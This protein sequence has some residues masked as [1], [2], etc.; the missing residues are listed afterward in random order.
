MC[1]E[2]KDELLKLLCERYPYVMRLMKIMGVDEND[3]EDVAGEIFIDAFNGLDKLRDADKM[4]PWLKTIASN[5]AS[6]YFSKR[7][8]R[9]EISNMVKTEAGEMDIFDMAADEI[10]VEAVLQEAEE[11][12]L[13][14]R[15]VNTLPDISRR[16][17]RMRFWGEYKH[18]EIAEILNIKLNTE[19]SIYRRSLKQLKRN[20]YEAFGGEDTHE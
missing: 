19:K 9:K 6:R 10:T 15:L 4:T 5:K 20:Y 8:R 12:A 3:I 2:D 17:I 7:R 11:R 14:E 16:I 13:V 1:T 18:S